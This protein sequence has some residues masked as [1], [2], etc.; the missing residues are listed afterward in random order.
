MLDH[1]NKENLER[2]E[3]EIQSETDYTQT[4]NV[5]PKNS[6]VKQIAVAILA[7]L[8]LT[9]VGVAVNHNIS[10]PKPQKNSRQRLRNVPVTVAK[11]TTQSIPVQLQAVG[12]VQAYSTVAVTPQVSG[13]I[14]GIFFKKGQ[15]VKKGQL[16]FTLDER[17]QAASIEQVRGTLSKDL[18]QVQQAKA[19][20]LKS[21]TAVQQA[22]ANLAKDQAQAKFAQTQ[23][24]RYNSLARQGAVAR[25]DAQQYT[26]NAQAAAA[27]LEADRSAIASAEAQLNID[28]AAIANAEAVVKADQA[29]VKNAQVQV[30][31]TKIYAPIDGRAGDILVTQGNVVQPG[32][33]TPLVKINKLRPVQ[34]SFAVPE[35]NLPEIQKYASGNKLSVNITFPNDTTRSVP[36]VL[37]FVNNAV[38][39]TTGTIQLI[40]LFDN[41]QQNLLPGQYVNATLTLTTLPNAIV[42]PSQAVQ[43]GPNGKF[44]FVVTDN[45]VENVPVTVSRLVNGLNVI[46]KGLT[47]GQTVVTDGQSNLVNGSKVQIKSGSKSSEGDIFNESF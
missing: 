33:T 11:V 28:R 47:P 23:S 22:K 25:Q 46:E 44:V 14:T 42:V 19:S 30:S 20:L 8:L 29:A 18:A 21:Q 41:V 45:T 36:G 24:E 34:V 6:R 4:N 35:T 2:T 5:K 26:A 7:L 37:T 31:Y 17:S 43:D 15:D 13:Q 16:L 38:D 10:K 27:G 3:N 39:S 9:G 1:L 40:G 12:N 32:S